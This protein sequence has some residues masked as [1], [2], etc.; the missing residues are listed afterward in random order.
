M[1]VGVERRGGAGVE[2]RDRGRRVGMGSEDEGL[3]EAVVFWAGEEEEE[4]DW[5]SDGSATGSFLWFLD[6]PAWFFN[7]AS[8]SFRF[9]FS[10]SDCLGNVKK[11]P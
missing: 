11:R 8:S 5:S 9:C 7:R 6:N 3:L 10:A 2:R 1:G 4:E